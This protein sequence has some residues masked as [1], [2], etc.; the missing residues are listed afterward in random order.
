MTAR[1]WGFSGSLL[2][3]MLALVLSLCICSPA[4]AGDDTAAY[5]A[6][7]ERHFALWLQQRWPAAQ[8]AGVS[9]GLFERAIKTVKLDWSL[10][11]LMLPDPAYPGGPRLPD[12]LKPPAPKRQAEFDSP[13][14]Y[15]ASARLNILAARG[16]AELARLGPLLNAIARR[17][18]VPPQIVLAIWGRESAFSRASMPYDALSAMATQ[19]FLGRRPV[20]FSGEF[21]DALVMLQQGRVPRAEMRSSWAGAM[22]DPQF[23]P[24]DYL[25][26]A[27]DFD[28]DGKADIW[29][30]TADALASAA[31]FLHHKGWN[32]ALPWGFEV[33]LPPKF[34][35]TLQGPDET[36][37]FADWVRLG[38]RRVQGRPF[39]AFI[40]SKPGFLVQPAGDFGP[41]FLVTQN[42]LVLKQYNNSD[43]YAL[44]VGHLA[45]MIAYG[46][47][48]SFVGAWQPVS[49]FARVKMRQMQEVLHGYG[50]DVG[51]VDGLVG[52]KTRQA[53]GLYEKKRGYAPVCYPTPS[54]VAA[55]LRAR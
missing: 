1:G 25:K 46:M 10:P 52:F 18:D 28:G 37:S 44:F 6:A 32:D 17:Y 55:L 19:G 48:A 20:K 22:G 30:S 35:C 9:R 2:R 51:K 54:V 4:V 50:Y 39:P 23:L 49:R 12:S 34:D 53:I 29:H 36:R 41:T 5:K 40:L 21:V 38:V 33:R 47:P 42:F 27:V 24:S 14:P 16:R 7:V 26:Y 43:L 11:L 8:T 45:D 31:N 3:L 13:A 15:F